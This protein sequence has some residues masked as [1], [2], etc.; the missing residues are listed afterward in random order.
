MDKKVL[1]QAGVVHNTTVGD[2]KKY[3]FGSKRTIV[4]LLVL[5][6]VITIVFTV[7]LVITVVITIAYSL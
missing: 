6:L 5:L 7:A 1:K 4:I 3:L 2:F